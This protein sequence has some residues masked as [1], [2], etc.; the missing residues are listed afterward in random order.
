MEVI[1]WMEK[2]ALRWADAGHIPAYMP[3]ATS[4]EYKAMEPNA[5]YASLADHAAFDPRSHDRR[6]RLAGLRRGDQHHRAGDARLHDARG[7]GGAD[8]GRAAAAAEL[9]PDP[10]R[11]RPAAAAHFETERAAMA[12]IGNRRKNLT[13]AYS[14]VAPF[15]VIFAIFF[16]Y[17]ALTVLQMSFTDA[18]LIGERQ[19]GRARQLRAALLRDRLFYTSIVEQRLLRPADGDPDHGDRARHRADGQPAEGPAA[20][21]GAG[22]LL[23]ALHPAGLGRHRDLALDARL[24]VRHPAAGHQPSS[25]ASRSRCFRNPLLGDADRSRVVTIWWTNGFNVLLFLA[26]LRNIPHGSLRGRRARRRHRRASGSGA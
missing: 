4:A 22:D 9:N 20:G 2:N 24:P 16:L 8:Q 11:P 1:G 17:P 21:P 7:R 19:L 5:T 18:P 13:V 3:V 14:L 23:P 25:P 10:R 12:M 6:R 15:V 26:G